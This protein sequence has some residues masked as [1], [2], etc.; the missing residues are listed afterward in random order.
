[1]EEKEIGSQFRALLKVVFKQKLKV[2][3][4][5]ERRTE[6]NGQHNFKTKLGNGR[7]LHVETWLKSTYPTR[8]ITISLRLKC[9]NTRGVAMRGVESQ[10]IRIKL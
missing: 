3:R 9:Q 10:I 5:S 1:M 4:K 8:Q 6:K 2:G 7:G